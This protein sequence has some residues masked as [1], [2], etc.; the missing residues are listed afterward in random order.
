MQYKAYLYGIFVLA[1]FGGISAY[2]VSPSQTEKAYILYQ[3]KQFEE[4]YAAYEKLWN[5]GNRS[6]SVTIPYSELLL[7]QG[8]VEDAVKV[9]E[10]FITAHQSKV[11]ARKHLGKLYQ[12]NQ[13]QDAYLENLEAI[14]VMEPSPDILRELSRIYNYYGE[15]DKQIRILKELVN[16]FEVQEEDVRK[17]AYLHGS[18]GEYDLAT[19]V[20]EKFFQEYPEKMSLTG[21]RLFLSLLLD[22]DRG[23]DALI[24]CQN[25]VQQFPEEKE[26]NAAELALSLLSRTAQKEA[27]TLLL[28]LEAKADKNDKLFAVLIE[29]K[30]ANKLEKEAFAAL[31]KRFFERELPPAVLEN[32][33][34]LSQ[35]MGTWPLQEILIEK[36]DMRDLPVE[37]VVG[38]G[39]GMVENGAKK[40]AEKILKDIGSDFVKAHANVSL[41][42]DLASGK[43]PR[44]SDVKSLIDNK[45]MPVRDKLMVA[46]LLKNV[47][48]Q[49][50]GSDLLLSISTKSDFESIELFELANLFMDLNFPRRGM[51]F[52]EEIQRDTHVKDRTQLNYAWALLA[53]ASGKEKEVLEWLYSDSDENKDVSLL[54]DIYFVS[55]RFRHPSLVLR[56]AT[57]LYKRLP[58]DENREHLAN[59]YL[60]NEKWADAI[61]FLQDLNN[62][63]K[64]VFD[65]YIYAVNRAALQDPDSYRVKLKGLI[66][67]G[68]MEEDLTD[69][70]KRE[71][72]FMLFENKYQVQA[73]GLFFELGK[74]APANHPDVEQLVY[75][76]G[77]NPPTW[78]LDWIHGRV[79]KAPPAEKKVWMAHYLGMGQFDT[80]IEAYEADDGLD[81]RDLTYL[82]TLYEVKNK[83][84]MMVW[85]SSAVEKNKNPEDLVS[86]GN[87]G[88]YVEDQKLAL[89][90]FEKALGKNPN[91]PDALKNAGLLLFD[92][93]R[94]DKAKEYLMRLDKIRPHDY[95]LQFQLGQIFH[96]EGDKAQARIHFDKAEKEILG[97]K[98][99]P[100]DVY[101][102][103]PLVYAYLNKPAQARKAYGRLLEKRATDYHAQADTL[104]ILIDDKHFDLAQVLA[105]QSIEAFRIRHDEADKKNKKKTAW[106]LVNGVDRIIDKPARILFAQKKYGE[107]F[108]ASKKLVELDPR[109]LHYRMLGAAIQSSQSYTRHAKEIVRETREKQTIRR[110]LESYEVE[111]GEEILKNDRHILGFQESLIHG[112]GE[113]LQLQTA[114]YGQAEIVP[115]SHL[116]F[117]A[118]YG[119]L[120]QFGEKKDYKR[121]RAE[122]GYRYDFLQGNHLKVSLYGDFRNIGGGLTYHHPFSKAFLDLGLRVFE[123]FWG[124]IPTV[125]HGGTRDRLFAEGGWGDEHWDVYMN[126]AGNRYQIKSFDHDRWSIS[127]DAYGRWQ[128]YHFQTFRPL[129]KSMLGLQYQLSGEYLMGTESDL[130]YQM[131]TFEAHH[132]GIWA[133]IWLWDRFFFQG[134]LAYG[135]E[136]Y[137]MAHGIVPNLFL[138]YS[139]KHMTAQLSY[140]RTI[141]SQFSSKAVNIGLAKLFFEF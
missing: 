22:Q 139:Y 12:Y 63:E 42:L 89:R 41:V 75:A 1:A 8:R 28:P 67:E 106:A 100:L 26:S 18:R 82:Q 65:T 114:F 110:K 83:T 68:L 40:S 19:L 115:H 102:I 84:T 52:F 108:D 105:N 129:E 53:A 116:H 51:L 7:Q 38:F 97:F 20:F 94:V 3:D 66:D 113:F 135:L 17:L 120:N 81:R 43:R 77:K 71:F 109:N 130:E 25:F 140:T 29:V 11:G 112:E 96:R 103:E 4:A 118:E 72:A 95:Y 131:G 128:F 37:L 98:I 104:D 6:M 49:K 55:Y 91:Q 58:D 73:I 57:D 10:Q 119:D 125:E 107:A 121:G 47:G 59:A 54:K 46:K 134:F 32:F 9:M 14:Y 133:R 33:V 15:Y 13:R 30:V 24:M 31:E 122:L 85:L 70:K 16:K 99:K 136:R 137:Q 88:Y 21:A 92:A 101:R 80:V 2:I 39:P 86:M 60:M 124:G 23:E 127:L 138:S 44:L 48:Y 126:L 45:Q 5:Q 69:D 132:L 93:G 61:P 34:S 141:G 36:T 78:G 123:P 87:L 111:L 27:L 62:R 64:D 56:F 50:H 90:A 79:A 35:H 117:Q 76:F 74:N